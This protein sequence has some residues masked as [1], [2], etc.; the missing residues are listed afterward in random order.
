M[1]WLTMISIKYIFKKEKSGAGTVVSESQEKRLAKFIELQLKQRG[2][3]CKTAVSKDWW[4]TMFVGEATKW[5]DKEKLNFLGSKK[6]NPFALY[7][8]TTTC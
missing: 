1:K 5:S 3:E 7:N 2:F 8:E 4:L 6:T